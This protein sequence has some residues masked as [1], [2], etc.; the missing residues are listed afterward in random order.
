MT[1]SILACEPERGL[2]GMA[3]ASSP[4][5]VGARCL[6]LAPGLGVAASQGLTDPA[7]GP[8]LLGLLAAGAT[9]EA[10]LAALAGTPLLATRQLAILDAAGRG[11]AF[12]GDGPEPHKGGIIGP[13]FVV[14][15]NHLA[16]P[17]VL[18]AMREAFL[19]AA[20]EVL[21]RRLMAAL[22]A[23]RD[24]G[25]DRAGCRSAAIRVGA[26]APRTDLRVDWAPGGGA[27]DAAESL[28]A[29]LR[30]WLPLIPYYE[31]RPSDP[32]LGDWEAW[33]PAG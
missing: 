10:A 16:S 29:L 26:A 9:P 13:G 19:A 7:L 11:A 3:I 27:A 18:P 21:E 30:R 20:G 5:A 28:A 23:R 25:G 14:L 15:G 17:Q 2:L 22:L 24:A 33:S 12:T 32:S 1:F 8:R 4:M 31:R 6:H